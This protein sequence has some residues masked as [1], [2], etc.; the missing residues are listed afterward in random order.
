MLRVDNV[1][2]YYGEVQA[3]WEVSFAVERGS[4]VTLVGSNGAG[5]TTLLRTIS[6]LLRPRRGAIYFDHTRL[7]TLPAHRAVEMGIAHIPEGRRLWSGLTVR[8]TL[9]LGDYIPRARARKSETLDWIFSLFP[10]LAERRSQP[11]DTLSGGEQ[12]MLA[13]ARG[14]L[15]RPQLL[16]LDEPSLGLAPLLVEQVFQ[17]IREVNGQGVTVLLVEQNVHHALAVGQRAYVLETGR[18]VKT[19]SGKDLLQDPQIRSAYLGL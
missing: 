17:I 12:Q 13:I 15:S 18:V 2:V 7:D 4:I 16:M 9:D 11:V 19:G 10:R 8:E 5:K 1:S 14:L 6:G 3:L